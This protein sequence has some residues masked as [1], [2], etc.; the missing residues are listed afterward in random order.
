MNTQQWNYAPNV[1]QNQASSFIVCEGIWKTVKEKG[2]QWL[3][4]DKTGYGKKRV[5]H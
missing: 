3:E 5:D 2:K 4:T 1:K